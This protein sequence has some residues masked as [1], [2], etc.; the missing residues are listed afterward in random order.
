[1]PKFTKKSPNRA[2]NLKI[3]KGIVFGLLTFAKMA[4]SF[5]HFEILTGGLSPI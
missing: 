1:M 5:A 4:I 3:E 2:N